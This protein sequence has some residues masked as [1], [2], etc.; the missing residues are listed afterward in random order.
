[1]GRAGSFCVLSVTRIESNRSGPPGSEIRSLTPAAAPTANQTA[2]TAWVQIGHRLAAERA[3]T[4]GRWLGGS[5][6]DG[7][8]DSGLAQP[9][10]VET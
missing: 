5:L 10:C 3:A 2:G 8:I 1:M 7:G 9:S 4:G 6:G